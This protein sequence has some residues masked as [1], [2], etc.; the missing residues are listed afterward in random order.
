MNKKIFLIGLLFLCFVVQI[1]AQTETKVFSGSIGE[2]RVQ[3]TLQ[4]GGNELKGTYFYQK[5]GK[6]LKV[7]G[8]IDAEGKF[9]L[10][11]TAPTG[12]KTGTF[13]GTWSKAEGDDAIALNGEWKNPQGTK[14]LDFYLI[15]QM[16][17]FTNGAKLTTKIFSETS[18][19]KLFEITAEY[20]ELSGV[21]PQLA[22]KFNQTAKTLVMNEVEKFRKDLLA[23]TGEDLQ[24]FKDIGG[25][26]TVE[27]SY[28]VSH[29]DNEI[30][31]IWFGNYFYT[32]G[33]HPNSYSFVL[34]FD[35]KNGK[36]LKLA[37]LFKPD[38][39]Y[40]KVI[41]DYCIKELQETLSDGEFDEQIKG[42]AGAEEKNYDSWNITR[43]GI[44]V[45]FDSYQVAPYVAGPQE[46]TVP[47]EVLKGILKKDFA[48]FK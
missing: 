32:G 11:E 41:S 25:I 40:L 18:K 39:N 21:S 23:Q 8:S 42:G 20:P 12:A 30:I 36:E 31:S 28:N 47:Y 3:M 24:F 19:P 4:R 48:V 43:K 34:N 29:A 16:I 33:A 44:A 38:S 27:I 17:F 15:E 2:S 46:V 5:V 22:A 9:T 13:S 1:K 10:T 6:D 14:T 26:N 7:S 37:D 35:L 45:T